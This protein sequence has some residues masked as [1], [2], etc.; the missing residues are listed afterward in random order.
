MTACEKFADYVIGKDIDLE[1]DHKPLVPLAKPMW[2]A[3]RLA[4]CV[5]HTPSVML[6]AN[7]CILKM[8]SPE[9]QWLY[10]PDST[11]VAEDSHTKWFVAEVISLLQ[12]NPDCLHKYHTAQ[13]NDPTCMELIALCKSGW[14]RKDQL[15]GT[16]CHTG[17][18][19]ENWPST[20][21]SSYEEGALLYPWPLKG[22]IG[23]DSL[24]SSGH[25][26]KSE[27][28]LYICMVARR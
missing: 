4:C 12:A 15:S 3:Y 6:R 26:P 8:H 10:T 27:S 5:S 2:I 20:M 28:S 14:H 13:H 18:W 9:H 16:I 24:Q 22:N 23:Q 21:T 25:S 17:Q 1:T 7:T 19:E 11:Q